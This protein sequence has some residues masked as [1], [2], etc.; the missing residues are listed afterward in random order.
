MGKCI[1]ENTYW[2]HKG[3]HERIKSAIEKL[4][5]DCG[6]ITSDGNGCLEGFRQAANCYYDL[7]NNGLCN[8]AGEFLNVFGFSAHGE[9][10][11]EVVRATERGINRILLAAAKEQ[12][13]K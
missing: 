12:G 8:R 2:N 1:Y 3:K 5:P 13:I 9:L 4:I 6:E 11:K 10:T 7:Y